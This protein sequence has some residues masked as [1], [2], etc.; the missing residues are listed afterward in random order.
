MKRGFNIFIIICLLLCPGCNS[1]DKK[2]PVAERGYLD[3]SGWDFNNKGIIALD[4]TWAFYWDRLYTPEDFEKDTLD[5]SPDYLKVPGIWNSLLIDNHRLTGFGYGT[6]YLKIKLNHD[7]DYLGIKL[8]DFSSSYKLWIN[9]DLVATNG[10]VS[11][12]L[13]EITPQMRAQAKTF[14]VDSDQLVLVVQVA[15]NFHHKGG[16]WES[17]RIGTQEQIISA[18]NKSLILSMFFAGAVFI[19]FIY[20]LWIYFLR[21]NEKAALWFGVLCFIL[22][23]RTLQINER[24]IYYILPGLNLDVSY[25]LQ[26]LTIFSLIPLPFTLYFFYLFEQSVSKKVIYFLFC[27]SFIEFIIILFTPT[28]F[29]TSCNIIFQILLYS[30]FIYFFILTLKQLNKRPKIA[31]LLLITWIV[32]LVS[33]LNDILYLNLVINT[34]QVS[35]YAFFIFLVMQAYIVSF[36]IAGAFNAIED[37]SANLERKVAERTRELAEEKKKSDNLLLNILPAEIANELKHSGRSEA[38]TYSMVTVMFTDFKD[39]TKVSERES[40][41]LLVAEIDYCFSAFDHIIQKY[42]IEKIKTVGDAYMCAGGLPALSYTHAQDTV[43]AAIEIRNFMLARK[44]EKESRGEIPFE[45]RI[46]VH[47]GPV[48]AGIV[49][50]KKFAYDIW[51]DTVNIASRMEGSSVAGKVNISGAT[52]ELVKDKFKCTYR[53]KVQAKSKGEVDMYFVEK[54][55]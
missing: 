55:L 47:T 39:F 22:L 18:Y 16:M 1:I 49:G 24:V 2:K 30:V 21:R 14:R 5:K 20:H 48:V 7:Y 6:Y 25:R 51:G 13:E 9:K 38:K 45:I 15:N 19:L 52:F 40:A 54:L 37:L 42:G 32:V 4:G 10:Q 27:I 23:F 33:G 8:L 28:Q 11:S 36:K 29:Y 44:T 41:E 3:L 17:I 43:N 31:R 12:V 46:G 53:G 34:A 26:Y 50:V 35:H